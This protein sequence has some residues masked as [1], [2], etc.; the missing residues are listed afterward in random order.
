MEALR[1]TSLFELHRQPRRPNDHVWRLRDAG[2][3]CRD[4]RRASRR[5]LAR[6]AFST[7]AT[8][9]SSSLPAAAALKLLERAMTNSAARLRSRPGAVHTACARPRA[10]RSTTSSCT[11]STTRASCSASTR[12]ISPPIANGC[13]NS[14]PNDAGFRDLSE[15]TGLVAVQGPQA[16]RFCRGSRA[17]R[18]PRCGA[19][20]SPRPKSRACPMH[21]RAHWLY[22]RGRLR[23]LHRRDRCR[24]AFQRHPRGRRRR[25]G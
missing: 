11:G 25:A 5:A 6:R 12:R 22:R 8:W 15:E 21:R 20:L 18:L 4:N 10:A 9:A 19:L 13:S 16:R 1:R 17:R 24:G 23:A 7:S 2:Q 14:A 3:L